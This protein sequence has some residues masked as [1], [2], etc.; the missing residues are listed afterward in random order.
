MIVRVWRGWADAAGADRYERHYRD[1]VLPKL[2]A[3]PG[4]RGARL[5]RHDDGDE[6]A[7]VS[8][9][10]FA[11]LAAIRAFAGPTPD[12]AVVADPARRALTRWDDHV[13]HYSVSASTHE[14]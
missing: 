11:D 1:E 5:L 13:T 8:L 6:T 7:F 2:R 3:I 4:F 9:T 14:P 12:R 10:E